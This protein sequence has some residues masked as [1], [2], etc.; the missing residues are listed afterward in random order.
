[1]LGC[2]HDI[3]VVESS[4]LLSKIAL[5]R[6]PLPFKFRLSG[7]KRNKPFWLADRTYLQRG[8]FMST[9]LKAATRKDLCMPKFKRQCLRI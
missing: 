1:M 7:V 3:N 9:T 5:G 4:P 6:Y 2:L 8:L